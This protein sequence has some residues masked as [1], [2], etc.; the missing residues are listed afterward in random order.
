[1]ELSAGRIAITND[2][3]PHGV[4]MEP[5][6]AIP[7]ADDGELVARMRSGDEAAFTEIYRRHNV[8]I[9]RLAIQMSG[10]RA[11]ADEVVQDV[12]LAL[13]RR[14][15]G[16]DPGRAA[17]STYLYGMARNCIFRWLDRNSR[18]VPLPDE[19]DGQESTMQP[20][21]R[22][23]DAASDLD[24]RERSAALHQAILALPPHYREAVALC[25]LE[26]MSYAEAATAAGC[27]IGT[28]RSRLNR[29]RTLLAE[30]MR[31]RESVAS[32]TQSDPARCMP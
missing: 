11:L 13:I 15:G 2:G 10:S 6:A 25:D 23:A 4:E 29:G 7:G 5:M 19:T 30:K 21:G 9:Y 26:E 28:I 27:S 20:A 24:A 1:L 8:M 16:Y 3:A 12:F 18:Y 32:A 17:L 22:T 14:G 31:R